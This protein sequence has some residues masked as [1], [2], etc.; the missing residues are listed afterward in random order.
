MTKIN[1]DHIE[2]LLECGEDGDAL[3]VAT[4]GDV[5]IID[6][7]ADPMESVTVL[8]PYTRETIPGR[9]PLSGDRPL[10]DE[11]L[12]DVLKA[13]GFKPAKKQGR[14]LTD[15]SELKAG[16][17]IRVEQCGRPW[18]HTLANDSVHRVSEVLPPGSSIAA[19]FYVEGTIGDKL[20][21]NYRIYLLEDA[22]GDQP[23]GLTTQEVEELAEASYNDG[24]DDGYDRGR[25]AGHAQGVFVG[26]EAAKPTQEQIDAVFDEGY[27]SGYVEAEKFYLAAVDALADV[28][29]FKAVIG[30][31]KAARRAYWEA[32]GNPLHNEPNPTSIK[33]WIVALKA[34]A[35]S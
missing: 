20:W 4:L 21:E 3:F 22:P 25:D 13:G 30:Y 11:E 29:E 6:P 9:W 34:A 32:I 17:L 19:G 1:T 28:E 16:Q 8:H 31:A 12:D 2:R 14:L 7:H 35:Q 27:A 33:A 26:S 18:L 10:T 24:Y 15:F 23:S 5:G